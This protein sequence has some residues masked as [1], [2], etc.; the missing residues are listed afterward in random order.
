MAGEKKGVSPAVQ[1]EREQPYA[2]TCAWC[3]GDAEACLG[4]S[5][6]SEPSILPLHHWGGERGTGCTTFSFGSALF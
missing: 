1:I 2:V 5:L 3:R 4:Q 6:F